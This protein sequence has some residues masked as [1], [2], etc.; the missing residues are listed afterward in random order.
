MI[1][2]NCGINEGFQTNNFADLKSY[3]DSIYKNNQS[4]TDDAVLYEGKKWIFKC[5]KTGI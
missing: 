4:L 3:G 1:V 5:I 2:E